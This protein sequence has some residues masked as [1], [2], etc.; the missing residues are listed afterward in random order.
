MTIKNNLNS[1]FTLGEL[2]YFLV[3]SLYLLHDMLLTTM[4]PYT[5]NFTQVL[6][7]LLVVKLIYSRYT[8]PRLVFLAVIIAIF[9]LTHYKVIKSNNSYLIITFVLVGLSCFVEENLLTISYNILTL[10]LLGD[11]TSFHN[12]IHSL[13][14][15]S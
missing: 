2:I 10:A 7:I 4:I 11:F 14:N 6:L 8:V 15:V 9:T 13:K 5:M 1:T 12:E 3:T